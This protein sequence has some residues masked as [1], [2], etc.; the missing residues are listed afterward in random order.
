MNLPNLILLDLDNT[1]YCY[2]N[3]HEIAVRATKRAWEAKGFGE[4]TPLYNSAKKRIKEK[5]PNTA[6]SHSRL[7]YMLSMLELAGQGNRVDLAL[8]FEEV[9]WSVFIES[10]TIYDYVLFK[11]GE[12]EIYTDSDCNRFDRGD[13]V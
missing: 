1:V 7:L 4:F 3:S 5:I 13:T 2:K 12:R 6:S 11:F 9:Y 10:T 8:E